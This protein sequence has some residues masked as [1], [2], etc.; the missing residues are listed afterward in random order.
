MIHVFSKCALTFA[1]IQRMVMIE[2]S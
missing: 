1:S 2:L